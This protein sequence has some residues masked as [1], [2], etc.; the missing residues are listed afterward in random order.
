MTEIKSKSGNK[1]NFSK[2]F[3]YFK[4]WYSYNKTGQKDTEYIYATKMEALT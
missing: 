4:F 3:N 2:N 1:F